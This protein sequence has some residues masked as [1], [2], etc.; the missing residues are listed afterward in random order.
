MSKLLVALLLAPVLSFAQTT[1]Q[2]ITIKDHKFSPSEVKVAAGQKVKLVIHNQDPTAE[3]FESHTLKR[4]KV[5][6]G[7]AKTVIFIG[8]LNPGRYP[9]EGEFNS[10]TAQGVVIA[11]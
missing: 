4:E 7:G 5:I 1:E 9:F 10:S 11:E 3:E 2:T 6:P 8:P